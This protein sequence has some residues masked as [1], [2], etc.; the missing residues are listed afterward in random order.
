[1]NEKSLLVSGMP[2]IGK[3]TFVL[4][5]C[6]EL[7][8]QKTVR[9]AVADQFSDYHSIISTW[10]LDELLPNDIESICLKL[11]NNDDILV[12][13]DI[14][15]VSQRHIDSLQELIE[16]LCISSKV[17]LILISRE[18]SGLFKDLSNFKLDALD[19]TSCCAM[20]GDHT[21]KSIR[22]NIAK[23]L[24]NHPLAL[25]LYNQNTMYPNHLQM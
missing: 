5:L 1:M 9:W 25:K 18:S 23:S 22:E 8:Q 12:I 3:S 7:A 6:Q 24:G 20:L 11:Q 14:N 13:D 16:K 15:L 2:G 10:Y 21:D 4:S 19:L 17:R